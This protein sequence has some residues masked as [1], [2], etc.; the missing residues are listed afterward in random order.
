MARIPT[1]A[2]AT[3]QPRTMAMALFMD[4]RPLLLSRASSAAAV[5]ALLAARLPRQDQH[6]R[7]LVV[8]LTVLP[9]TANVVAKDGRARL[10]A[11]PDPARLRIPTT[12]NACRWGCGT[13]STWLY[14]F[15][16][17]NGFT[18]YI[19]YQTSMLMVYVVLLSDRVDI[20]PNK[21]LC[22][23]ISLQSEV[24]GGGVIDIQRPAPQDPFHLNVRF[25]LYILKAI[26]PANFCQR[27]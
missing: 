13:N 20:L 12:L 14:H 11:P 21:T 22:A 23:L 19:F 3:T 27:I 7:P 6:Q 17:Y 5:A 18:M 16:V 4:L 8:A 10:A 26:L 1:V 25:L 9:C 24:Y 15:D 2:T